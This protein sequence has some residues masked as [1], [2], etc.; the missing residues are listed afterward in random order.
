[1][2]DRFSQGQDYLVIDQVQ[3][4]QMKDRLLQFAEREGITNGRIT[5]DQFTKYMQEQMAQRMANRQAPAG[6][7]PAG[8]FGGGNNGQPDEAQLRERFRMQDRNGDGKLTPDEIRGPIAQ[9]FS[10]W[11]KNRDGAIDFDEFKAYYVIRSQQRQNANLWQGGWLP[12]QEPPPEDPR[13]TVYRAGNLPKEL[14]DGAPWFQQ[15]DRDRDGQVGLYE[16]KEAGRTLDEFRAMDLNGDGFVTAEED[17]RYVKKNSKGT[18]GSDTLAAYQGPGGGQGWPGGGW[19]RNGGG[20]G[21]GWNRNGGGPGWP[22]GGWNRNGGGPGGGWNRN[23][24]GPGGRWPGGGMFPQANDS[25]SPLGDNFSGRGRRGGRG[26][27]GNFGPG[28]P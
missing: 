19:N 17:L 15:M 4:P 23:G 6:G 9:D 11:D 1:M 27:S 16:W 28:S 10:L 13:P 12:T 25:S 5:R 20:P 7:T 18:P 2:F 8:P 24:G 21:G 3:S 14:L 26:G 22:G